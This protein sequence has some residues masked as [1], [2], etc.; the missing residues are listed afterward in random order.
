M[1]E[2]ATL[3]EPVAR[4]FKAS[5]PQNAS[6]PKKAFFRQRGKIKAQA[7]G[8]KWMR[9]KAAQT[10]HIDAPGFVWNAKIFPFPLLHISVQDSYLNGI[11]RG[12]V[13]FM[14]AIMMAQEENKPELNL[15]ALHRYLGEGV[16]CPPALLPRPG[17]SWTEINESKAI[18]TLEDKGN[19]VELEFSFTPEGDIVSVF[20]PG[21]WGR[22]KNDYEKAPWK[23]L[24][25]DHF[26]V[27]GFR[28][29][30]GAEVFW[31]RNGTWRKVWKGEIT[32]ANFV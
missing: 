1:R 32:S 17:L 30:K 6:F 26:N 28:I 15:G 21:R 13:K 14:S 31:N 20:S 10:F 2:L 5:L 3:P 8:D 24:L 19:R 7:D 11:G 12:E 18:A 25:Y 4:F 27:E 29:P 22:F 23:V 9:F 16:W